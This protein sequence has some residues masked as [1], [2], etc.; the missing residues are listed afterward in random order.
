MEVDP[1]ILELYVT[2]T[3]TSIVN[4]QIRRHFT[5]DTYILFWNNYTELVTWLEEF[6]AFCKLRIILFYFK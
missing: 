4:V 1:T 3:V 2:K 6:Q 5:L